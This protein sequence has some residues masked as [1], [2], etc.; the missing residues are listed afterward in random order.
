MFSFSHFSA[1]CF[2]LLLLICG[3]AGVPGV[4]LFGWLVSWLA[5]FL[6][7]CVV[8]SVI[9][10]VAFPL[11]LSSH[12]TVVVPMWIAPTENS[13]LSSPSAVTGTDTDTACFSSHGRSGTRHACGW[14]VASVS[15]SHLQVVATPYNSAPSYEQ[16]LIST[17]LSFG[18]SLLSR[19]I[20]LLIFLYGTQYHISQCFCSCSIVLVCLQLDSSIFGGV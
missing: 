6:A 15:P 7:G 8:L 2:H 5:G 4:W 9:L 20:W 12:Q 13:R 18:I 17:Y 14:C 1:L 3:L 16:Q 19:K 11:A 10:S